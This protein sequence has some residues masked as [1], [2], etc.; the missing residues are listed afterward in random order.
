MGRV[1]GGAAMGGVIG[2]GC[3]YGGG[4]LWG[5]EGG[6]MPPV[7]GLPRLS[8]GGSTAP[9]S[10]MGSRP[11]PRCG[12]ALR[13]PSSLLLLLLPPPHPL[14][15]SLPGSPSAGDFARAPLP[16]SI[17]NPWGRDRRHSR[18]PPHRPRSAM[19]APAHFPFKKRGSLQAAGPA[20]EPPLPPPPRIAV[21]AVGG[22]GGGRVCAAGMRPSPP[23]LRC[24]R[25]GF[26]G[27]GAVPAVRPFTIPPPPPKGQRGV[28]VVVV[29]RGGSAAVLWRSAVCG[30]EEEEEEMKAA[31]A[32]MW[33][34]GTDVGLCPPSVLGVGPGGLPVAAGRRGA[35]P[36]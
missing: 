8:G 36:G 12:R 26:S 14:P 9:P 13:Q 32:Q 15:R 31:P 3:C 35:R 11:A 22:G 18:P 20:G 27:E 16:A 25:G 21:P 29:V 1:R 34:S 6:A 33:G 4:V 10:S 28:V 5:G 24:F 30:V 2:R 17:I 7:P 23:G 19:A